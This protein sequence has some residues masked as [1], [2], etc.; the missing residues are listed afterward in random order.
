M[1]F[2]TM[3]EI[4]NGEINDTRCV[5]YVASLDKAKEILENNECDICETCYNYATIENIPEGIYQYDTSPIWFKF[6]ELEEKYEECNK[7]EESKNWA[8]FAIG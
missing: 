4:K 3:I 8:G 1:Y 2:I 6:N 7:P 5:G